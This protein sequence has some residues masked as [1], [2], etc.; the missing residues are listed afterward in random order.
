MRFEQALRQFG[1][2]FE[3]IAG[4]FPRRTRAQIKAKWIKEDKI[5]PA[6]I[7]DALMSK[8]DIGSSPSL[9]PI[10]Y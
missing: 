5:N 9:S 1:T 10:S 4:L 3:M 8:K 6:L 7:T 2:D